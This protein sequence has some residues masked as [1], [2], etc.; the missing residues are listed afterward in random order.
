LKLPKGWQYRVRTLSEDLVVRSTGK[1][2][3]LQDDLKNSYQLM[4]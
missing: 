4:E 1:A 3:V 2:H